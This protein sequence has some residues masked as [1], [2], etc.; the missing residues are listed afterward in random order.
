MHDVKVERNLNHH[1][2]VEELTK[3]KR[4]LIKVSYCDRL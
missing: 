4:Q 3:A 2:R 1:L